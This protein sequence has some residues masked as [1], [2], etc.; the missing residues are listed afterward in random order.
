MA[1][2]GHFERREVILKP[3]K[4]VIP[5]HDTILDRISLTPGS[6]PLYAEPYQKSLQTI[7]LDFYFHRAKMNYFD[8][9]GDT[10]QPAEGRPNNSVFLGMVGFH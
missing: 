8:L 6:A 1:D 4:L 3:L 9:I 10:L 7:D 5:I 2:Q